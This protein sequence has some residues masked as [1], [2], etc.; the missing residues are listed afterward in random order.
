[1]ILPA[2]RRA[3]IRALGTAALAPAHFARAQTAYPS[4][5]VRMVVPFPPGGTTD[6][7]TRLVAQE[8]SKTFGQPLVV[9]NRPGA[10]TVIGVDAVAKAAPD[11]HAFVTVANSFTVNHT[12][13]KKL[14]Y[15]TLRDL[16][17]VALLA[18]SEHVL[19][20]NPQLPARDAREFVALAR[21]QP[22]RLAYASFGN[23][24]SAHLAGEMLKI[25]A[26]VDL[27]HVPYKGQAPALADVI[28]GQV[29]AI[30]ANLPEVHPQIQAG[31]VRA[32]GLAAPA[33]S[34]FAPEIPTLAEQDFAGI[35]SN[36]W[37]GLLAPVRTPDDVV[38]RVNAEVNRVLALPATR[39]AFEKAGITSLARSPQAFGEFLQ[40]EIGR[41][42]E[43]IRRA[44]ITLE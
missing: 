14:P 16:R 22:G 1:M 28:G 29:A 9:E 8:L 36:S 30:F 21:A 4:K 38:T 35:E 20:V 15:D 43:V 5:P 26:G 11:G 32:L 17:P 41:Y 31:R 7:V 19:V 3:L 18:V 34:R 37:F 10:G 27:V 39:E 23:G 40:A 6:F 13:L 2:S 24:T 25:V 42:A 44:G 33:R 12:L